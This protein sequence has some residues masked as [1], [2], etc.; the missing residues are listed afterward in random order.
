MR[1]VRFVR[2]GTPSFGVI[3]AGHVRLADGHPFG[4][5]RLTDRV[6]SLSDVSLVAPVLP[7]KIF[8]VAHNYTDQVTAT[9][10]DVPSEP[11][12]FSKPTTSV[13][14][15]GDTIRLPVLST[16]VDYEAE[17]AVVIGRLCHRVPL[18]R[19]GDVILGYTCANDITARDLQHSDG[20]WTRAKGFDTFSPLGPWIETEVDPD[21]G[22]AVRCVVDGEVRQDGTTRDLVF[23]VDELV[24][25]VSAFCTL[26]PGDV[27]LT[28]TPAG[29]G[30]LVDGQE[31]T[32]SIEGIGDL[33]NSVA[34]DAPGDGVTLG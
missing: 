12:I 33:T 21:D 7:S 4:D 13:I 10:S 30:Q 8:G 19:A 15:S 23:G 14:G 24:A 3:E 28:G 29:V 32:V 16:Q 25:H 27:I 9:G 31:V 5:L 2:G 11:L 22:L 1:I 34:T 18:E 20:Q 6:V 26:L 17:L